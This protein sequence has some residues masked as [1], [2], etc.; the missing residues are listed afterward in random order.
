MIRLV[1]TIGA[2]VIVGARLLLP[3]FFR[4]FDSISLTL[5][6]LA[7]VPWLSEFIGKVSIAGVGEIELRDLKKKIEQSSEDAQTAKRIALATE[8]NSEELFF[9]ANQRPFSVNPSTQELQELAN[10]YVSER[11][12]SPRGGARTS[13][14]TSIFGQM[15]RAVEA[16]GPNGAVDSS[17]YLSHDAG[18]QLVWIAYAYC[19]PEKVNIDNIV[20]LIERS[21]QSFIQYWGLRAIQNIIEKE[22][23]G[24]IKVSSLNGLRNLRNVV[25]IKTDRGAIVLEII[26]SFG[27]PEA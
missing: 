6:L 21:S 9:E 24:K 22:G 27:E 2:L 12:Q 7:V 3:E 15:I 19:Y 4:P 8:K 20:D 13:R 25:P 26:R 16:G 1:I 10:K 11:G 5:L 23:I 14:M 17:W 18:K